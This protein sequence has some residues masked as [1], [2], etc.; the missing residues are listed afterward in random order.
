MTYRITLRAAFLA[1]VA[2]AGP[3]FAHDDRRTELFKPG[4][5]HAGVEEAA[6]SIDSSYFEGFGDFGMT[7]DTASAE[8]QRHFSQGLGLLWGFNHAAAVQAFRAAQ[9]AD[10]HCAMCYWGEAYALGPNL[11]MPMAEADQ[12]QARAASEKAAALARAPR[13]VA[14][15][16]AMLE[17]YAPQPGDRVGLDQA[18]ANAMRDVAASLP[19]DANILAVCAD[20]LM[21]LQPWDYWE[22]DGVTPKGNGGEILSSLERAL[23]LAPNHPAALHLYIHAVEAS[24][25]P[26]RAEAAADRL[27]G[28][29]PAAGHLVHMPAHIY[30]R[31]GRYADMIAVN[32]DAVAADEAYL[33]AAGN[34][35]SALYRFG[36]YPHNVHFLLVGSQSAGLAGKA[37]AAAE[38]LAAITSNEVSTEL[39]WVQAILTAPFTAHAQFSDL[40]TVLALPDPGADFPF[41]QGFRHFARGTALAQAGDL[42]GAQAELAAIR[43]LV[44]AADFAGLEAQYLPA[45]NVLGIAGHMIEAR[46]A[47]AKSEWDAAIAALAAAEVLEADIPYMEPP[48]WPTPVARTRGAVELQAARPERAI[49][50]FEAAL[51]VAPRDGWALWGLAEAKHAAG[52]DQADPVET[53]RARA[54]FRRAWLG[55]P[56]MLSLQRL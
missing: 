1:S 6:A 35:A 12:A 51:E 50:A 43:T 31:V 42:A 46:I 22:A 41:L 32:E 13:E 9:A 18:F 5:A 53:H 11:N 38:K 39:A 45:K 33:A 28:L 21:N 7:V 4:V 17:R 56:A 30:N 3:A 36:Y 2:L 52:G 34:R 37:V 25:D 23:E 48:Y 49:A 54:A 16:E 26:G 20:A 15:A 8:A 27:R 19:E 44:E 47:Q 40:E 29:V 55:D 14:L 24:A 10:P